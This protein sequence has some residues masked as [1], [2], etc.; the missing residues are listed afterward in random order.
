[1]NCFKCNSFDG[2]IPLLRCGH[3]CCCDCYVALKTNKTDFCLLCNKKLI[4]GNK[5]NKIDLGK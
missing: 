5:K 4:R 2:N 3:F 1:M